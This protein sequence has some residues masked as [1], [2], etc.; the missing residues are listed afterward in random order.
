MTTYRKFDW[1]RARKDFFTLFTDFFTYDTADWTLTTTE[2]GSGNATE[3]VGNLAGGI[4]V[5]TNDDADNDFDAFQWAGQSGATKEC[6]KFTSGKSLQFVFRGKV[7]DADQ[8]D[9]MAGLYITDTSPVAGVTDGIFFRK[10]DDATRLYLVIRKND[11]ETTVDTGYDLLDDT[12]FDCEFYYDGSHDK[13]LAYVNGSP[14]GS[15]VL[16]NV[17][18]DEELALSFAFQ[19]GA[20]AAKV[21]SVDYIG[22]SQQR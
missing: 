19:N 4:L 8:C 10:S 17:P 1:D 22:A 12:Y 3:A 18:D 13:I 14:S 2:A 21:L 6:F 9:L 5:V 16:T 15:G 20:A 11:T 7:S